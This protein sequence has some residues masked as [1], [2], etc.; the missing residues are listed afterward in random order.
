MAFSASD[1]IL[2]RLGIH[3]IENN[4]FQIVVVKL[5]FLHASLV[6][7]KDLIVIKLHFYAH[8]CSLGF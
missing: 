2:Y 1:Y 5:N 4:L 8:W 7:L 6:D 3:T